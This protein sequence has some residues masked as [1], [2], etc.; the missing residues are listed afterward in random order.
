M[1]TNLKTRGWAEDLNAW[2]LE[3]LCLNPLRAAMTD[4]EL[5]PEIQRAV[6]DWFRLCDEPQVFTTYLFPD[7]SKGGETGMF[8]HVPILGMYGH[9]IARDGTPDH[10]YWVQVA[11]K[12]AD[13]MKAKRVVLVT[14]AWMGNSD[15]IAPHLDPNRTE[16]LMAQI[17]YRNQTNPITISW[18]IQRSGQVRNL[19]NP[20]VGTTMLMPEMVL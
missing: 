2:R 19:S 5:A 20:R 18:D 4:E 1:K 14:E 12:M 10:T 6:E 13:K 8:W 17:L 9:W 16:V 11:R 7:F 15:D 3:D